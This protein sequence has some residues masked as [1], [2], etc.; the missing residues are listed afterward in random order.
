MIPATLW[1]AF[2]AAMLAVAL[3][4]WISWIVGPY[5]KQVDAGPSDPP[6]WMKVVLVGGQIVMP[7]I[8]AVIVYILLIRPWRRTGRITRDGILVIC[9]GLTWWQEPFSD[10]FNHWLSY[11]SYLVNWGSWAQELPGW[12]SNVE[13]GHTVVVPVLITGPMYMSLFVLI[14]ISGAW[15]MGWLKRRWPSLTNVQLV[16]VMIVLGTIVDA[17]SETFYFLPLGFWEYPGGI[18]PAFFPDSYAKMPLLNALVAGVFWTSMAA[19][20]YFTNDHDETV[21]ESGLHRL[22]G[23]DRRRSWIRFFALLGGVNAAV[24][25]FN[26]PAP[27]LIGPRVAEWPKDAQERSYFTYICGAGTNIICPRPGL[28]NPRG[29]DDVPTAGP[30][31][32]LRLKNGKIARIVPYKKETGG[33]FRGRLFGSGG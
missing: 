14:A 1:A 20:R 3:Y 5:F 16:L 25:T 2:G 32:T 15:S 12:S 23:S 9:F 19:L 13:P 24:M 10:Y 17:L 8:A 26:L 18:G 4:V 27:L 11:N 31:G 28:P 6:G 21:P 7:L 29:N 33:P 30:D 22:R